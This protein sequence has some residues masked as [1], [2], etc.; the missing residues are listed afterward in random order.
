MVSGWTS[1]GFPS[2]GSGEGGSSTG[3]RHGG[4]W[5][6]ASIITEFSLGVREFSWSPDGGSLLVLSTN[7]TEDWA[8]LDD[9]ERARMPR[10]I[11]AARY[12]FD[13]RGWLHDRR[14]HLYVVNATGAGA[15]VRMGTGDA[16]ESGATWSPDGMHIAFVTTLDDPRQMRQGTDIVEIELSSGSQTIRAEDS[17]FGQLVY[18]PDGTLHA[19]GSTSPEFPGLTSLWSLGEVNEDL[20][21][22]T[23]RSIFSFLLPAEMAIPQWTDDGFYVGFVD[24]G[25]VRLVRF[26][27]DEMESVLEGDRYVTGFARGTDDSIYFTATDATNSGELFVQD[28]DGTERQLTT[29]NAAFRASVQLSEPDHY[30]VESESGVEVDTWLFVPEGDGPF[31]VLL[32]IHG[33]PASQYGFNFFDEFQVYVGAG[34]AV[35]ACNPRGSVGRGEAWLTAVKGDAWGEVD[36]IDVTAVVDDAL[37][38]DS[39]LDGER[40]GIMGGSYG[41]FLS[42]W[43]IADDHRYRSAIVERALLGWESFSGTSDI[44]RDFSMNYL[45]LVPPDDHEGLRAKSPLDRAGSITTPTLIVHSENDLRCPVEQAEQLFMTLLRRHVDV[46]TVR[47]PGESHELSRS[48]SPRH[49]VERF[50]HILDWHAA[51]LGGS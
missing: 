8:D 41:G 6:E 20:T 34:Y 46:A 40:L 16:N 12:R 1:F 11:E 36:V 47:F 51:H 32:N 35:L 5:G 13:S 28:P 15:P 50:E 24:G 30:R 45:G 29:F 14:D 25:R 18:A 43:I 31:P 7:W 38:T 4:G 21:G 17:G 23:D 42:A 49:R 9:D 39:R 44:A 2:N 19:I 22:H 3:R 10:K 33:G 48:G 26:T 27:G 37:A